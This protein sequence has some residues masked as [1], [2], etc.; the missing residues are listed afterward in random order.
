MIIDETYFNNEP[1]KI[2]GLIQSAGIPSDMGADNLNA[3]RRAVYRF[4]PLYLE[5][6]FGTELYAEYVSTISDEKWA[7]LLN[8]MRDTTYKISPVANY[9]YYKYR[10]ETVI[11]TSDSGDYVPKKDNMQTV[12]VN[13]KLII[14]WNDMVDL[15]TRLFKWVEDSI[16]N[17]EEPMITTTAKWD[18]TGWTQLLKKQVAWL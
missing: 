5:L 15:N 8:R 4:E 18:C 1:C 6:F 17:A 7:V 2:G 12:S 10:P 11:K 3:L 9:V 13:H 14:A 16:I